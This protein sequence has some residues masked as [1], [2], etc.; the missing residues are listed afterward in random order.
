[1]KLDEE[2]IDPASISLMPTKEIDTDIYEPKKT[3]NTKLQKR[4]RI[5]KPKTDY[6]YQ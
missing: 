1:M 6:I 5:K 4:V 2:F 3:I